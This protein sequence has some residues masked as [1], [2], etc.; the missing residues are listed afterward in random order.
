M[1]RSYNDLL[2]GLNIEANLATTDPEAYHRHIL[3]LKMRQARSRQA[4]LQAEAAYLESLID[5]E[6]FR[7]TNNMWE[8]TNQPIRLKEND[9]SKLIKPNTI[10]AA[11][12]HRNTTIEVVKEDRGSSMAYRYKCTD[13]TW[14]SNQ[15]DPTFKVGDVEF[16]GIIGSE[17]VTAIFTC[18]EY[19]LQKTYDISPIKGTRPEKFRAE[20]EQ[21]VSKFSNQVA[22]ITATKEA[23][24]AKSADREA[25]L[26]TLASNYKPVTT[27]IEETEDYT[28]DIPDDLSIQDKFTTI[29]G[30][31]NEIVGEIN[32]ANSLDSQKELAEAF[33]KVRADLSKFSHKEP[34]KVSTLAV[35][36]LGK[37][38]WLSKKM[39]SATDTLAGNQSVKKNIDYI[40]G[41][42]H[43]KYNK[44]VEV[45]E[46]LQN[47]RAALEAQIVALHSLEAESDKHLS[48][49]TDQADA[50]MRDVALNT[51]IKASIQ[52]YRDRI[53]KV[54]GAITA[55]Q[56][57]IIAL[58]R[59][60]PAHK[61]DLE[62][63]M[64]LSGLLTNIDDYQ[65]MF[66]E[67]KTLVI[68][69]TEATREK[70]FEVV[71]NLMK[72]QIE[73]THTM[74]AIADNLQSGKE[75]AKMLSTNSQK[76]ADKTVR[77]AKFIQQV[78]EGIP[79]DTVRKNVK[80]LKG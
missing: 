2:A 80:K 78:V 51:Q 31:M 41:L 64:A 65:K 45:A 66:G 77:D 20:L 27:L 59:D 12:L 50:P 1:P 75:F 36:Y 79:I 52:K 26:T 37:S 18:G 74:E 62:D 40:F 54:K 63:E 33:L 3:D 71:D 19:S 55:M 76:L 14:E 69:V 60:L 43:E 68:D 73:D 34:S 28:L 22:K 56:A 47:S 44:L 7:P 46:G 24:L 53:A 10:V 72:M 6:N 16:T 42:M 57:T 21:L 4:K 38:N 48:S 61:S 70:T 11:T 49:F 8:N 9:M 17:G 67:I 25:E 29:V 15:L 13:D 39:E 32:A 58:G 23:E 30:T 5:R 35:K